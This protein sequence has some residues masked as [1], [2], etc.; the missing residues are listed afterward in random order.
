MAR[1]HTMTPAR[2]AA[3]RKAQLAS[4]RKRRKRNTVRSSVKRAVRQRASYTKASYQARKSR[5]R[6]KS[7][8]RRIANGIA[9]TA[10]G[11]GAVAMREN[12]KYQGQKRYGEGPMFRS[13]VGGYD[14]RDYAYMHYSVYRK[15]T[16]RKLGKR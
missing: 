13:Q 5:K 10:V 2:R 4:A 3:L 8:R 9:Y 12:R 1:S 16:D 7:K 6:K 14:F 11:L 15:H